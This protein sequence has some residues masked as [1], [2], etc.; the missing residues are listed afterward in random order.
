MTIA[1]RAGFALL[2]CETTKSVPKVF[3]WCHG[4]LASYD[5]GLPKVFSCG[6]M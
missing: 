5:H 4:Q 2:E 3:L 6:I 1:K